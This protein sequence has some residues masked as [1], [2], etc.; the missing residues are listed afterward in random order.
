[1]MSATEIK[2]KTQ[3]LALRKGSKHELI[4]KLIIADFFDTPKSSDDVVAEISQIA[5]RRLKS[6]EVQ[7]Y[8]K[9]FMGAD[10]IRA[11]QDEKR[12]GNFWVLASV[13][14]KT[15]LHF[16]G[17]ENKVQ[18]IQ[19]ELFSDGL[20]KKLGSDFE[21]EFRDL[22]HNFGESG[23]CTAFLL[24]KILEKLIYLAFAKQ[25][26]ALK[27]ADKTD[28]H[29]LVGLDAM[30]KLAVSEKIG[31]VPFLTSKTAREIQW[32]KFLGDSAAHNPLANVDMKTILPQ[33]P[34]IITAFE[35]LA[36]KM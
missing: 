15:A 12:K 31:G 4:R 9:K 22:L 16:L 23:T 1:M 18:K 11:V 32:L 35:E 36:K 17:K 28:P 13:D 26:Q 21:I 19:Q 6:S 27:L 8:M 33:M 30:I 24:R 7:P 3:N 25:G 2:Q 34:Y 10:I 29:R 5:G 14:K 20:L